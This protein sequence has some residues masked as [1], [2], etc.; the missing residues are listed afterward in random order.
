ME[1]ETIMKWWMGICL[2]GGVAI[3]IFVG[4]VVIKL[5]QHFGVI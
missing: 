1:T 5:M 4:W 2:V 3:L